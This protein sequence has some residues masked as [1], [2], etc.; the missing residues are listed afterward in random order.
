MRW[1]LKHFKVNWLGVAVIAAG[2]VVYALTI[3]FDLLDG[4]SRVP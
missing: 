3:L 4:V 1:F 2:L